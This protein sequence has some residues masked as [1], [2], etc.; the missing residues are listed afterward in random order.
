MN[1]NHTIW[2]GKIWVCANTQVTFGSEANFILAIYVWITIL[3]LNSVT[4]KLKKLK[5]LQKLSQQKL[6]KM[7]INDANLA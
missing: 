2:K 5:T 4:S 3:I 7:R 1:V 6:E